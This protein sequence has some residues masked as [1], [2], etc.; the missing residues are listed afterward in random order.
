MTQKLTFDKNAGLYTFSLETAELKLIQILI[1]MVRLGNNDIY[2]RAAENI[3]VAIYDNVSINPI[4]L[5]GSVII[6]AVIEDDGGEPIVETDGQNLILS[7]YPAKTTS[8]IFWE[9]K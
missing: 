2:S 5:N 8:E 9:Q 1:G 3:A 4:D 6:D 7:I